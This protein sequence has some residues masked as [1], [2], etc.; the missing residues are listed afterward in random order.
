MHSTHSSGNS[1]SSSA[2]VSIVEGISEWSTL[3]TLLFG[4][5]GHAATGRNAAV[6]CCNP[7][8]VFPAGS[9]SEVSSY[10]DTSEQLPAGKTLHGLQH[11][12][13]A[14]LP[15]AAW[16]RPPKSNVFNVLHSLIPSTM[17]THALLL[18]EFPEL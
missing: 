9:C 12:T 18:S 17:L 3:K 4:G 6:R 10:D 8:R 16:P 2:C 15:V 14:F 13:A 1:L 5:R 7:W 11:R